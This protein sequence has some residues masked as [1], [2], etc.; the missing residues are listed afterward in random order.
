MSDAYV[1]NQITGGDT[2]RPLT[3]EKRL[4]VLDRYLAKGKYKRLEELLADIALGN[5]MPDQVA[6][7][8]VQTRRAEGEPAAP[9]SEK[10]GR[11]HV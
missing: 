4:R 1:I 8:L 10:I 3:M 9:S 2:G 11:A 5:R 6:A 7:Q